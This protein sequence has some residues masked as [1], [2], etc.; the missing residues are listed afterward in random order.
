MHDSSQIGQVFFA[1]CKAI[2]TP[3]SLGCWLRYKYD[4]V[5]LAKADINPR[6]YLDAAAF[7]P[8]YA[9]VSFLSKYKGLHTGIDTE[10]VA[11]QRFTLAEQRC[12]AA[13]EAFRA[14]RSGAS[15]PWH[16]VFHS[17]SRKI[18]RLLGP[19]SLFCVDGREGWGPG[20]TLEIPRRRAFPDT[21]MC[22]LPITVTRSAL[23]YLKS[24][25]ESDLHWSYAILGMFPEGPYSLLRST[26]KVVPGN[27]LT[28]VPKNAKTDRVIAVEPRG[29]SFLQKSAG[30]YIRS[31]LKRV[32]VD[33]NDQTKN[34][35]LAGM[36]F[37]CDLATIDLSMASD[38]VSQEIVFD[39]LPLDWALFLNELRSPYTA[40]PDG[41]L[42]RLEKFS[43]MGNGFT[44]ELE[45]LIFWAITQ[46]ITDDKCPGGAVAVYGDD[47]ICQKQISGEVVA[48]LSAAGFSVNEDKTYVDGQ[49]YESCGEHYFGGVNVTP[50]YQKEVPLDYPEAIRLGNRLIRLADRLGRG[51]RLDKRLHGAWSEIRRSFPEVSDLQ[52]PFGA[53]G[54]DGWLVPYNEFRFR[55]TEPSHGVQCRVFRKTQMTFPGHE[56]SLLAYTYRLAAARVRPV[57][58][59]L[60]RRSLLHL[61]PSSGETVLDEHGNL[62]KEQGR[63]V[64]AYRWVVPV[65][66]KFC[67]SWR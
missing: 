17:A 59:H 64:K 3:V 10:Q 13:N 56:E 46:A 1:L 5:E 36:A 42:L 53:E 21:K 27:R 15:S 2:D 52:L 8:D 32:G 9:V 30:A 65:G 55:K 18:A 62:S 50:C 28:T 14:M 25:I 34:Q 49:F 26:F 63:Y 66:G 61:S 39:L 51:L 35:K 43:S 29:N 6:D 20:A 45:T 54:D 22:E 23:D 47:I 11:L 40:M 24:T 7:A 57:R 60:D 16:A 12:R 41:S 38:T 4:Q 19:F 48:A 44:F 33:L 67:L 37:S 31:R 58:G